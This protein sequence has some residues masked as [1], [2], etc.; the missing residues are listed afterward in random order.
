MAAQLRTAADTLQGVPVSTSV[1]SALREFRTGEVT[2]PWRIVQAIL[3]IHGEYGASMGQRIRSEVGP[4]DAESMP[5]EQ[6]IAK[7]Y[8]LYDVITPPIEVLDGRLTI[9][10]L[11]LIDSAL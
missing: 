3:A 4:S 6:W 1:R 11:A 10:G 7:A 8:E 5:V 2:T 9:L